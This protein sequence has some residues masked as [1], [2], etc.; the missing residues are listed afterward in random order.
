MSTLSS[1]PS[2]SSSNLCLTDNAAWSLLPFPIA[3]RNAD[4]AVVAGGL[5][6]RLSKPSLPNTPLCFNPVS[7]LRGVGLVML[8]STSRSFLGLV[9]PS[10]TVNVA[11]FPGLSTL[12]STSSCEA[13]GFL[14]MLPT[15]DRIENDAINADGLLMLESTLSLS[16]ALFP[17]RPTPYLRGE[18]PGMPLSMFPSYDSFIEPSSTLKSAC[19]PV[20]ISLIFFFAELA[21]GFRTSSST[22]SISPNAPSPSSSSLLQ[23]SPAPF[24]LPAPPFS[25]P[26]ESSP[27]PPGPS[28]L[29]VAHHENPRFS[30]LLSRYSVR[31]CLFPALRRENCVL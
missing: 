11:V 13:A 4:A 25:S 29:D 10:S 20:S 7:Y 14:V 16:D 30:S 31:R 23:S 8:L 26:E 17:L 21:N 19:S 22:L 6:T 15:L 28:L 3:Y 5:S 27:S 9:K 18:G 12:S 1:T 2:C 24:C